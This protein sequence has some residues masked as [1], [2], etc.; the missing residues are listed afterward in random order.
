MAG[1]RGRKKSSRKG[2]LFRPARHKWLADIVTFKD[3]DK[4]EDAAERLVHGMERGRIGRMKVGRKRALAIYRALVNAANRAEA[5]AKRRDLSPEE[6][7][8]LREIA[9]IYREAA[10]EAKEIYHEKYA[11]D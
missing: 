2:G 10:E 6:R 4:A 5:S 7:R 3:P 11:E 1:R 8:K 9:E